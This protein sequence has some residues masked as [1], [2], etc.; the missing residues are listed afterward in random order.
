MRLLACIVCFIVS[1][2]FG[3][4][5]IDMFYFKFWAAVPFLIATLCFVVAAISIGNLLEVQEEKPKHRPT[6]R[7]YV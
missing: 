3:C 7:R 1:V 6:F 2:V 5:T 4:I